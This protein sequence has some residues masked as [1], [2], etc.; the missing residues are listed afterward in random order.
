MHNSPKVDTGPHQFQL[1]AWISCAPFEQLL[2]IEIVEAAQGY[3]TLRMPFLHEFAQGGGLMHGG[4]LVGLA[5]TAV[6]MSIKS[7]LPEGTHFATTEIRT[8]FLRPV[9]Q[10]MLTAKASV[11]NQEGRHIFGQAT[12]FDHADH[13]V[14]EFQSVFK[15][16]RD[17]RIRGVSF[18]S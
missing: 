6:V 12:V 13:P 7:L 1:D 10:G 5:D 2:Q 15:V 16:A 4:A 14:V 8:T 9:K 18:K 17:T 3:A 11:V